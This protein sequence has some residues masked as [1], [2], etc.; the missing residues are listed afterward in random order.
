M[1]VVS[2]AWNKL[3]AFKHSEY[4]MKCGIWTSQFMLVLRKEMNKID[5]KEKLNWKF[6]IFIFSFVNKESLRLSFGEIRQT[7]QDQ[8]GWSKQLFR[9]TPAL[10]QSDKGRTVANTVRSINVIHCIWQNARCFASRQTYSF[11]C[12]SVNLVTRLCS[13]LLKMF[14]AVKLHDLKFPPSFWAKL[15]QQSSGLPRKHTPTFQWRFLYLSC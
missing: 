1:A 8:T 7:L 3:R 4:V 6:D 11:L 2:R 5:I 15:S 14:P 13:K 12:S 10:V 9:D